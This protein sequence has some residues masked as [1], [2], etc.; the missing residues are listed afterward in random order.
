MR[1]SLGLYIHIPFCNSKCHYCS[2]SSEVAGELRID[3]YIEALKREIKL[4]AKEFNAINKKS[5]RCIL[6]KDKILWRNV[7]TSV[8]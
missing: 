7:K 8:W 3:N 2:F 6:E 5:F 4:R 1:K